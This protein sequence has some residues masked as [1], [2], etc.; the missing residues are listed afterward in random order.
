[1]YETFVGTSLCDV[2]EPD[3]NIKIIMCV[4]ASDLQGNCCKIQWLLEIKYFYYCVY[5]ENISNLMLPKVGLLF[6]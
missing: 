1:M 5:E 4:L 3:A 2:C 6:F